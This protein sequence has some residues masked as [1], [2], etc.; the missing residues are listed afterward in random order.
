MR[1][2]ES[3]QHLPARRGI[4]S[5]VPPQICAPASAT[6]ANGIVAVPP[7]CQHEESNPTRH[8]LEQHRVLAG[9][10][11]FC[12]EDVRQLGVEVPCPTSWSWRIHLHRMFFLLYGIRRLAT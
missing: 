8:A 11:L 9:A 5:N 1:D 2:P 7:S 10:G 12:A 4:R 6:T 3:R